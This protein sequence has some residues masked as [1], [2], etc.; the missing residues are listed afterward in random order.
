MEKKE[1]DTSHGWLL[2]TTINF[3]RTLRLLDKDELQGV[4]LEFENLPVTLKSFAQYAAAELVQRDTSPFGLEHDLVIPVFVG[5]QIYING[6]RH[7]L[8]RHSAGETWED[9]LRRKTFMSL[10]LVV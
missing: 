7:M 3:L 5:R 10:Y 2:G 9:S 4:I 1:D 6:Q 8:E